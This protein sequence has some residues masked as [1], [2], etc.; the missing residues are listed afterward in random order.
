MWDSEYLL[1]RP[2]VGDTIFDWQT[3]DNAYQ[4]GLRNSFD[5]N[6][7]C[8]GGIDWGYSC[9]VLHVLQDIGQHFSI[10]ESHA[11]EYYELTERCEDIIDICI[12]KD[13]KILYCDSNPKDANVTLRKIAKK[14]RC[15]VQIIP[16]VFSVWKDVG[17]NNRN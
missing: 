10:P 13:I 15:D 5:K 11:W 16:V 4:R 1:K 6:T 17:I 12:D 7:L 14:K 3:V 2:K 9:T 8:E